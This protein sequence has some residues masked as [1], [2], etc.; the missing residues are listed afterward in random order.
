MTATTVATGRSDTIARRATLGTLGA[1]LWVLLP[2]AWA[3][4][5]PEDHALGSLPFVA[6]TAS[7]WVFLV[8]APAL[9]IA[10]H[11]ALRAALGSAAGGV[12][13][14]GIVLGGLG[15][16]AMALGN[17]IEVA[18]ISTGGGEVALGHTIFLIGF[19]GSIVGALLVGITVLRRRRDALS[20][21][22]GWVLV[23]AL[24]LGIGI[25]MLSSVLAPE[26]DTGFWAAISVPAGTAWLLL[27]RSLTVHHRE[28]AGSS[29]P[30][31]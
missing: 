16:G 11:L 12:G 7:Y 30:T 6:V 2:A 19:L 1:A 29:A 22:A 8:L 18:S 10:G 3:A 4:G 25:G 9:V 23:L 31:V 5:S 17:G 15:F 27:G 14:A 20:R 21:V 24:P 28:P 13:L 26:S